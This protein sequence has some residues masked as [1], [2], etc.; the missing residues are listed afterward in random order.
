MRFQVL[1]TVSKKIREVHTAFI[2]TLMTKAVC[3][4]EMSLHGA[5]SQKALI[6]IVVFS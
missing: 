2:F 4:S 1:T 6:F 3:T 5:V